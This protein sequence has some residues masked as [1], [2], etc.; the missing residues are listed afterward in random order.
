MLHIAVSD[1][2]SAEIVFVE[3]FVCA[4]TCVF[5]FL[6]KDLEVLC[7]LVVGALGKPSKYY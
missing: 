7:F 2:L 5:G 1:G 6:Q 3:E 4:Y